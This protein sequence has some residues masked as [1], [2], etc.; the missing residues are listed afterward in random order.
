MQVSEGC[1]NLI[2]KSEG[3]RAKPYRCPAGIP[4]IGYG[5][6]RYADG[7]AVKLTDSPITQEQADD[8]MR[9]TLGEYEAAV[10]RYVTVEINQNQFDALVDFAYN[11]GAQNL[12]NS[13]LLKLLNKGQYENAAIEFGKWVYGGGKKLGGLVT[14]RGLERELFEQVV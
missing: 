3:F 8:I 7:R 11:A 12:K 2:R 9:A 14:R 6:T 13:T 1:L 4:T 5:S 10:T